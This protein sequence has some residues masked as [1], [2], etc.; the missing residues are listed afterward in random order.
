MRV[1]KKGDAPVEK[2][3]VEVWIRHPA[4]V[5]MCPAEGVR[6]DCLVVD[7]CD[8]IMTR[9]IPCAWPVGEP[10]H[11]PKF[12]NW[13]NRKSG[14]DRQRKKAAQLCATRAQYPTFSS[15]TV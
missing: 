1:M 15:A 3:R 12:G 11:G 4:K 9:S 7:L 6:E 13:H 10:K 8:R 14:K 5:G 2:R